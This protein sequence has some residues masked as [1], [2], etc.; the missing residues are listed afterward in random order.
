MVINDNQILRSVKKALLNDK[1]MKDYRKLL[2]SGSQE[3]KDLL[4]EWNFENGLLF[5]RGKVYISESKDSNLRA[6]IISMHH[7][8]PLAGHMKR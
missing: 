4:N 7:D 2:S 1:V 3:F 8:L 5:Y 6:Q